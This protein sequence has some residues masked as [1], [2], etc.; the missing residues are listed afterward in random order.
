MRRIELSFQS[1]E[2]APPVRTVLLQVLTSPTG[3]PYSGEEMDLANDIKRKVRA[4]NGAD[5]VIVENAE[6]GFLK[7]RAAAYQWPGS[8]DTYCA[9]KAA[10]MDAREISLEE[11]AKAQTS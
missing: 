8:F 5:C 7:R 10:I 4:A 3:Q 11:A 6:Y 1:E 2:G 9:L